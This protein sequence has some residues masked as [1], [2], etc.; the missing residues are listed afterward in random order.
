LAATSGAKGVLF[1]G[2]CDRVKRL[3]TGL[4]LG[5]NILSTI[6]LAGSNYTMQCLSAP[7]RSEID[8]A[9]NRKPGVYLDIGVPGIRNL[10]YISRRRVILWVALGLSSLPLHLL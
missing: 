2:D 10:G 7:T 9:H 8:S 6:L 5:I 4:H 1:D 3:N